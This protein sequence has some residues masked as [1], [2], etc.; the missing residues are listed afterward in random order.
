[1]EKIKKNKPFIKNK[2]VILKKAPPPPPPPP[3]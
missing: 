2:N 3:T 1:L